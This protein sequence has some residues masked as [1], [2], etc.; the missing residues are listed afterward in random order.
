MK[1]ITSID[2]STV[3]GGADARSKVVL[4]DLNSRFSSQGVVSFI[5]QPKFGPER[6]GVEHVSGKFDTNALWGG[7]VKR[8]FTG[9]YNVAKHSFGGLRTRIIGSE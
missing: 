7:D 8:T 9:E 2:L 4:N 1:T 3:C 5:G 6:N